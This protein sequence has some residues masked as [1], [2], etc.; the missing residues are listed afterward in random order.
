MLRIADL[1]EHPRN[2]QTHPDDQIEHLAQS[3]KEHGAYRNVVVARGNVLLAGHGVIKAAKKLDWKMF[4][5]IKLD[6]E[7]DSPQALK[8]LVGD[9][10]NEHLA[11]V[12]DRALANMLKEILGNSPAGLL[13]TGYDEMMLA[14]LAFVTRPLSEI[15]SMDEAAQWVGMPEYEPASSAL[16]IV[17]S[18][19][20]K[21]DIQ[22]FA[23]ALGITLTEN[24]RAMWWPPRKKDDVSSLK[25][26][27]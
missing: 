21:A 11:E 15:A 8:I 2:Y 10:E 24:T 20:S 14:N 3:L 9:N 13:G 6:I 26:E 18:F 1:K 16:K 4:P 17:V 22:K 7:P 19:K 23:K 27:V 12:D 25:F 5:C